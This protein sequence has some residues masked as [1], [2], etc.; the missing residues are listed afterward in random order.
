MI[1]SP[2]TVRF[3]GA[4]RPAW[5][6]F[7]A[8]ALLAATAVAGHAQSRDGL[9][10]QKARAKHVAGRAKQSHYDPNLFDLSDLP[11]YQPGQTVSGTIRLW[12][13]NYVADSNLG[14]DWEAGFRR[15]HPDA[16][17]DMSGMISGLVA[18]ASLI[19]GA[20]DIAGNRHITFAELEGFERMYSYDPLPIAMAR[21]SYDVPGWMTTFCIFVHR[22]NPLTG[23]TLKQLD[24]IFGT[25]RDGGWDGTSWH[26]EVARSARENIRT[27]GQL[28]LTGEWKD[29]PIHVYGLNLRYNNCD[30]FERTVFHG[31][32]KWNE[33]LREYANFSR[34]DGTLAIAANVLMDDLS[35][36]RYGIG[37][38]GIQNLTPQTK[39]LALAA[40]DGGPY[41]PLT[42][43]TVH[44]RTYP[45]AYDMFFYVNRHPGQPLDPKVKEF[46]KYI[47]SREGQAAVARDGKYL[48]LT[49]EVVREEMKKLE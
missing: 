12:G 36:D 47:L 31:G 9:E 21:G 13:N 8:A 22:D 34:A 10:V 1:P 7:L 16:H 3:P 4:R 35:R 19:T 37:W 5:R 28:G 40:T 24:G 26:P 25:A 44:D 41:V 18:T 27:W 43:Q 2:P 15:Y 39:P 38:S 30:M 20:A 23:L 29:Q 42:I 49:A 11:A 48:P 33:N 14:A 46:L 32:D 6:P 45:L 17:L